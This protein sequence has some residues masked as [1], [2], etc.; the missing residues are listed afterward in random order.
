MELFVNFVDIHLSDYRL[1]QEV[2]LFIIVASSSCEITIIC[3][4][5]IIH[6]ELWLL[7]MKL[8]I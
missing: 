6:N 5:V 2:W 3:Y 1:I 4:F 8:F 7:D